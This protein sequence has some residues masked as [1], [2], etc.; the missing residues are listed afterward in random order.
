MNPTDIDSHLEL[1]FRKPL[2]SRKLYR[3]N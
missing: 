3:Q 1:T 2:S